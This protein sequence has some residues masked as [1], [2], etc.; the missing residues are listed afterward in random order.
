[1]PITIYVDDFFNSHK[2]VTAIQNPASNMEL[3]SIPDDEVNKKRET[4]LSLFPILFHD[5]TL[6]FK[7]AE[8]S[9]FAYSV[10]SKAIFG[11]Q[12][13]NGGLKL[14]III[15]IYNNLVIFAFR[16]DQV[17]IGQPERIF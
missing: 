4:D 7:N 1:M 17:M 9:V 12:L 14:D 15:N 10:M 6:F 13:I 11:V 3:R 8:F 16:T 2:F 5:P